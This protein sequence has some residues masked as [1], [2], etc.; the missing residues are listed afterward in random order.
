[1][2]EFVAAAG[3]IVGWEQ[4]MSYMY[5]IMDSSLKWVTSDDIT[6]SCTSRNSSTQ[7]CE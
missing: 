4:K 3:V 1:M 7:K 5:T 6:N 2:S